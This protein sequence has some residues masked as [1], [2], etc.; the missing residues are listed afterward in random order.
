MMR[1]FM[2]RYNKNNY[3]G[4]VFGKRFVS[5]ITATAAIL[6][7]A[8]ATFIAIPSH[9]ATGDAYVSGLKVKEQTD[10]I[11][12]F[13]SDDAAGNDSSD[14]NLI[15][16]SFD[17][18]N[19]TIEFTTA[20]VDAAH[21]ADSGTSIDVT[22]TLPTSPDNATWNL[23]AM[24]WLVNGKI[25]YV[26]SD[27]T[28][29]DKW[30]KTK[31]VTRQVLTGQRNLENKS[32]DDKVPGAAQ[33]SAGIAVHAAVNGQKIQPT[34]ELIAAGTAQKKTI[35]P[36]AVTVS[37]KPRFNI[38]VA[39]SWEA[40]RNEEYANFETGDISVF[41]KGD[42]Y[43]KGRVYG[44]VFAISLQNT[45]SDKGLKG[46]EIPTGDM[47]FDLK[48]TATLDGIDVTNDS[49][50]GGI[51]WDYNE[52]KTGSSKGKLG[53]PM[54]IGNVTTT[55]AW[56]SGMPLNSY[57][58][59]TNPEQSGGCYNGGTWTAIQDSSDKTIYHVTIS[60]Y[61]IDL[62][63]FRFP[64]N[65][66]DDDY[67]SGPRYAKNIGYISV[68][69]FQYFARFPRTVDS[70]KN[71]YLKT[72]AQNVRIQAKSG[73]IVTEEESTKD[74]TLSNKVTLYQPGTFTKWGQYNNDTH[75]GAGDAT[76]YPGYT[77]IARTYISYSGSKPIL[78]VD[79]LTKIDPTSFDIANVSSNTIANAKTQGT[80]TYWY[81]AKPDGSGWSSDDE[82]NKTR[83][84]SLIYYK[85]L[86]DI[87]ASGKKCIGV[88]R[89]LRG[90]EAYGQRDGFGFNVSLKTR[91]DA[92]GGYVAP[93]V[94]DVRVWTS[95]GAPGTVG[96]H[97]NADGTYGLGA[98]NW[99]DGTYPD[100]YTKPD[101]T[102]AYDY[103]KASY[104][105][106]ALSGGHKGGPQ[107]G[108]SC[109]IVTA[110]NRI[111]IE[112][113]DKT[114]DNM[115][116]SVYDL[117]AGERKVQFKITPAIDL[118]SAN[119][120][121]PT[122]SAIKGTAKITVTLPKDLTYEEGSCSKTVDSVARNDNGTTTITVIY[123]N[124]IVGKPLDT[125]T[126]S[127]IIGA[128]GTDHDV[129]NNQQI[130]A[131]AK[132]TS[133]VDSRKISSLNGNS[134]DTA[135]VVVRL[136][137]LSISKSVS[138]AEGNIGCSHE[139]SLNIGN[140][141]QTDIDGVK[142]V[143]TMPYV[144]DGRGT[145]FT[146]DYRIKKIEIDFSKA[147]RTFSTIS[148]EPLKYT[149]DEVSRTDGDDKIISGASTATFESLGKP[150]KNN[151]S[152]IWDNIDMT[153]EQLKAWV[154]DIGKL[155]GTQ[156]VTMHISIDTSDNN[157]N[158]YKDKNGKTQQPNDIYANTFTENATYQAAIVHS[159]VVK[160]TVKEDN[161]YIEKQWE[162]DD[163]NQRFRPK[164]IT[165]HVVS[166]DGYSK[167][168]ILDN[169]TSWSARL[170]HLK[171]FNDNGDRIR[172]SVS[173]PNVSDD[174]SSSVTGN[175]TDGFTIT[176]TY[177]YTANGEFL[178]NATK[179]IS[180]RDFE[181]GDSMTF[182]ID[183]AID[184]DTTLKAPT[185]SGVDKNGD[186]TIMP[187]SGK[188][189][190][191]DFGKATVDSSLDG[192]TIIYTITEKSATG[193]GMAKDGATKNIS[194]KI[195]DPNH[196]H[197]LTC[198]VT[199]EKDATFTN[200]F[201]P[202]KITAS[203]PIK[204]TL[205][206]REWHGNETF[207]YTITP[208]A[209]G[210]IDQET[211]EST[212]PQ[213]KRIGTFSKPKSGKTAA[214]VID[215]FA[216]PKAGTYRYR[217]NETIPKDTKGIKYDSLPI[218]INITVKSNASTGALTV[219]SITKTRPDGT[220][221]DGFTNTYKASGA[222]QITTSKELTGRTLKADEFSFELLDSNGNVIDTKS[223]ASNGNVTFNKIDIDETH[224][225]KT[226]EYTIREKKGSLG[227][228]TYD[229]KTIPVSVSVADNGDGT[230]TGNVTYPTGDANKFT[231]GYATTGSFKM[232]G[233]KYLTGREF[234][235]GDSMTFHITGYVE[236]NKNEKAPLPD[237]VDA[238]G[239]ITI[240]PTSGTSCEIPFGTVH[241][242]LNQNNKT[243]I[244]DI[245]ETS[246][247]GTGISKDT[248]T[249]HAYARISDPNENGTLQVIATGNN[250]I[251]FDN[252]FTPSP[253]TAQLIASKKLTGRSWLPTDAFS[254]TVTAQ[255]TVTVSKDEAAATLKNGNK[256]KFTKP[257]SGDT[258]KSSINLNISKPGT[259]SYTI[260]E[261][262][263]NNDTSKRHDGIM[264]SNKSYTATITVTQ[265]KKTG[266]LI[267]STPSYTDWDDNEVNPIFENAYEAKGKF[268]GI[269]ASKKLV[270]RDW[271]P[272]DSFMFEISAGDD[273][274]NK[275]ID[276]GYVKLPSNRT[277]M[278]NSK[279]GKPRFD[280]IEFT[281]T[282]D[283][284]F[285]ISETQ[286]SIPGVDIASP[287]TVRIK[288]TDNNNGTLK[289]QA[290]DT[291]NVTFTDYYGKN[292][293]AQV[294]I[295]GTKTLSHD[296]YD[297]TPDITGKYTFTVS[298]VNGAKTDGLHDGTN[299]DN[300]S[301][302]LGTLTFTMDDF[303]G[304]NADANGCRTITEEYDITENGN[305]DG[306]TNDSQST[307]R[308]T[309]T[310]VDDGKGNITASVSGGCNGN[311]FEFTNMF[312][313]TAQIP[314]ITVSKTVKNAPANSNGEYLLVLSPDNDATYEAI[315]SD[316]IE[317]PDSMKTF[318]EIICRNGE[319]TEFKPMIVKRAGTYTFRVREANPGDKSDTDAIGTNIKAIP[320][321]QY[322]KTIYT[323][324]Y[325]V[326]ENG[327]GTLD[328]APANE[329]VE[330]A[331]F[332][333]EYKASGS[334][335]ITATK[336]L[337]GMNLTDGQFEFELLDENGKS[338]GKT[339][340]DANGNIT[341]DNIEYT[342]ADVGD[343]RYTIHEI[344]GND[345]NIK[346]D[347]KSIDVNVKVTDDGDGTL[348]A[349]ASYGGEKG[350]AIFTNDYT[351][352][353]PPIDDNGVL[354]D[355]VQTGVE[356]TESVI[357]IIAMVTAMIIVQ[358]KRR[359]NK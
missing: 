102:Q 319:K 71:F 236:G 66:Y 189:A 279:D 221:V 228:I 273:E 269:T 263:P 96:N 124:A 61:A 138:P 50:Y 197:K 207:S 26:Y 252:G 196:N 58:H 90:T 162:G 65:S 101:L 161:I 187:K 240:T 27:G 18:I 168:V 110:R 99:E 280:A 25:Q 244:Y 231:N 169:T 277:V 129:T 307:K 60:G 97:I 198:T 288:V 89:E 15:V 298:P 105:D 283:Y 335:K 39:Q 79:Q 313:A 297:E 334:S 179:N 166:D 241:V 80:I 340:N 144:G 193:H 13:D 190:T 130:S 274:T 107:W 308:V 238:A 23:Q 165:A 134:A 41:D 75:W 218:I 154:L 350:E 103:V 140:N 276:S 312:S 352:P 62:D 264:Y 34:F 343:H 262:C 117:D 222:F 318:Q 157:G 145:S 183:G 22:F 311:A 83:V 282:G 72:V 127:C 354:S 153:Q 306:V 267:A 310:A 286:H 175:Q 233:R 59:L 21:P 35:A 44:D 173:E 106:G 192:K 149:S 126:I 48:T 104:K 5:I 42:G 84:E 201:T 214:A 208:T 177:T 68:G 284:S 200:T 47:T 250:D 128:A 281:H 247:T 46:L 64:T 2:N 289:A 118:A 323:F 111:N 158:L 210:A 108:D 33:L 125:F 95:T 176:N 295:T 237:G 300:G 148:E 88:L 217:V 331:D 63:N 317:M 256:I 322:D 342:L 287:A 204:K 212:L 285:T 112:V 249:R 336:V 11:S 348:A 40:S 302:N 30:D 229:T 141:S 255:R 243:L 94:T 178:I 337:N 24:N 142:M 3:R 52:N 109:L 315:T 191:I 54:Q 115:T 326:S 202:D 76:A 254:A 170:E 159:N 215:G 19:Y 86:N 9:A 309:V 139:W 1:I 268:D 87:K 100:N 219:E 160:T 57:Y 49:V 242:N 147:P 171:A 146:G 235:S 345:Q 227:G 6:S 131:N 224:I 220:A 339:K 351:A 291:P 73:A 292:G 272:S 56:G 257:S 353:N 347:D 316:I 4:G 37:A 137:A 359:I 239:N 85:T 77:Q 133:T 81:A 332:E 12:P 290:I 305:V 136:A 174:Y 98:E 234:K 93:F 185:L 69:H 206:G 163:N 294:P 143:D 253:I 38:S 328:V 32:T 199:G 304:I 156:Y 265:D 180:G 92:V 259:Y 349:D 172:Y 230:V 303:D 164:S 225:G 261:D 324:R 14:S 29:S 296:G 248:Q 314:A 223:N 113:A 232:S 301:I 20:L 205:T 245:T 70:T 43:D 358:K 53:R 155:A 320:G 121:V 184:G 270:G 278:I 194:V 119:Q 182:H 327:T 31:A 195:T 293:K 346:Y 10:G 7:T 82:M 151:T 122:S 216:F 181:N 266:T 246:V 74:N 260:T 16:R 152:L 135:I 28:S 209:D 67:N 213:A 114:T 357:A 321:V 91:D 132:I 251:R 329:N 275:A 271:K 341:F 325:T 186:I 78:A 36:D 8:S 226:L 55:P 167:D 203:V 116:K 355:L 299:D 338:I 258:A 150:T 333:N 51:L 120:S 344:A 123:D 17:E 45:S 211:A 188:T 356:I 330:S